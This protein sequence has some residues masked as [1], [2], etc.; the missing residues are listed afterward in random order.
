MKIELWDTI[1][2]G[3]LGIIVPMKTGVT[4][5]NQAGGFACCHPELEGIY[6]PLRTWDDTK[7]DPFYDTWGQPYSP[8]PVRA[9]LLNFGLDQWLEPI[10]SS[11]HKTN[12]EAWVW[13]KIKE[14]PTD[15]N[16]LLPEILRPLSGTPCVITYPNSD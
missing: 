3:L 5:S 6:I 13:A 12:G 2:S 10:P 16:W 14:I 7:I 11:E 9:L 4:W 8:A 1:E 15:D